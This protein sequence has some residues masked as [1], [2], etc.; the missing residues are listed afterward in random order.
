VK[1]AYVQK[2][3]VKISSSSDA[4]ERFPR[5]SDELDTHPDYHQETKAMHFC[6]W[7]GYSEV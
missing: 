5:A 1:G 3:D 7:H 4:R 2:Q 6:T